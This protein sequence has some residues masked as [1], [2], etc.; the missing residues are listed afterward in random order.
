M[1]RIIVFDIDGTLFNSNTTF[2]FLE[3]FF[4]HNTIYAIYKHLYKHIIWRCLNKIIK[5]LFRKDITR[6]IAIRFLKG[7]NRN[8]LKIASELFYDDF[9]ASRNNKDVMN[10]FI[11]LLTQDNNVYLVSA[12]LDF[13]GDIISEKL[14]C[15]NL[16]TSI[17][18]YDGI[19]CEGILCKDLLGHKLDAL[20]GENVD[21]PFISVYTDDF[22]DI[23]ILE[24]SLE[25]NII[26]NNK[27]KLQWEKIIKKY[28]WSANIWKI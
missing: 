2:D 27:T 13:I 11:S 3:F 25:K 7:K 1:D 28:V 16:L 20:I 15:K 18:S 14:K 22:T 21:I 23:E 10:R 24:K 6:I 19:S 5:K 9:L 8:D 17:I 4:K 12:T 26:V